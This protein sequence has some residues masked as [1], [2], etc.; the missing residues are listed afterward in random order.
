MQPLPDGKYPQINIR[1]CWQSYVGWLVSPG[2]WY[3]PILISTS[4]KKVDSW[5]STV[6]DVFSDVWYVCFSTVG[7]LHEIKGPWGHKEFLLIT[8]LQNLFLEDTTRG[9]FGAN[10]ISWMNLQRAV[11]VCGRTCWQHLWLNESMSIN[12]FSL[13]VWALNIWFL[14]IWDFQSFLGITWVAVF[15]LQEIQPLV[16]YKHQT[17]E[18][19]DE[20]SAPV[21]WTTVGSK[22]GPLLFG[23]VGSQWSETE[24]TS[25]LG[26]VKSIVSI[27]VWIYD[28]IYIFVFC[29]W[30]C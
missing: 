27:F 12:V 29:V 5:P 6:T 7:V 19:I 17:D 11:M 23:C 8:P 13:D 28:Y 25:T 26:L 22:R 15:G 2:S 4:G 1:R 14:M 24:H 30:R 21:D 3:E 10:V 16:G 18:K 9:F 20:I